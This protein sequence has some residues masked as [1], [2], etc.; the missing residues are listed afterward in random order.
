MLMIGFSWCLMR[1][2]SCQAQPWPNLN[3]YGWQ[4][5]HPKDQNDSGISRFLASFYLHSPQAFGW[6][7]RG[8]GVHYLTQTARIKITGCEQRYHRSGTTYNVHKIQSIS[9]TLS[10]ILNCQPYLVVSKFGSELWNWTLSSVWSSVSGL[11]WTSGPVQGSG[12]SGRF[13]PF[14]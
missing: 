8:P 12:W 3:K 2:R 11:N 6:T 13:K 10:A 14:C 4:P 1:T 9:Q 7:F 5:Q